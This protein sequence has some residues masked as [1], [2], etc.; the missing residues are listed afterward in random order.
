MKHKKLKLTTVLLIIF[1][2]AGLQAQEALVA[3]GGDA[4]GNGGSASY[5]LGQL[6]YESSISSGGRLSEGVQHPYE[7]WIATALNEFDGINLSYEVSPNPTSDFLYLFIEDLDNQDLTYQLF[8]LGGRYLE[9]KEII[10]NETKIDMS[11][12]SPAIYFLK[13]NCKGVT[14][15]TF[16]IIKN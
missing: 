11:Q 4:S 7:I 2:L 12:Y 8:D 3:S 1:G 14:K 5:S 6:V 16:K 13:I 10:G 15:K 9:G